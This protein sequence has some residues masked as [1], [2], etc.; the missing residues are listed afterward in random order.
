MGNIFVAVGN[1]AK[2]VVGNK[3]AQAIGLGVIEGVIASLASDISDK[4]KSDKQKKTDKFGFYQTEK[5]FR[6][7]DAEVAQ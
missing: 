1:V 7:R 4:V 6:E 2:N 5:I 3:I